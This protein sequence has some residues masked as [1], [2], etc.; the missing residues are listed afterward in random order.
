MNTNQLKRFAKEARIKLLSQISRKMDFVLSED[1]AILRGKE[2]E[3]QQLKNK[4]QQ[5]GKSQVVENV[6]YTWFN[7]LMALRFMN[8]NGYNMPKI[9]TPLK[10]M[11][12]PE[13]LQNTLAGTI[14]DAL[15]GDRQR[16]N[17]LLDGKTS[18]ADAQTEAYKMILVAACNL[19]HKAMPFT[20]ER[21][22]DYAE[23]LSP[24]ARRH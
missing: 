2:R 5:L 14:D 16:L 9:V 4:I 17:E 11:S 15:N 1:A 7:R 13:I 22:S 19:N 20:F 21:I 24:D 23:L 18:A 6:A 8:A 10:G 3:I 12:N